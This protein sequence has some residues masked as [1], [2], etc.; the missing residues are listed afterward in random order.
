MILATAAAETP[1]GWGGTLAIVASLAGMYL[2]WRLDMYI[3]G[4]WGKGGNPSPTKTGAPLPLETPQVGGVSSHL[5][6]GETDGGEGL[7][8]WWGGI[9][10]RPDGSVRRVWR[11]AADKAVHIARTGDA[12]PQGYGDEPAG[13]EVDD[14]AIGDDVDL[15]DVPLD[16]GGEFV[17]VVT[18]RRET[19]E[20]YVERCLSAGVTKADIVTALQ[21]HYGLSRATA[22]RLVPGDGA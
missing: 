10:Q 12:P 3:R 18:A 8:D 14:D 22:Y 2:V 11:K 7:T 4:R 9:S 16:A 21:A 17:P 19:R 13:A 1:R 20:E 15:I 5:G 6:S